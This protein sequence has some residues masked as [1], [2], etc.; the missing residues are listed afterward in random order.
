VWP[1]LDDE[2]RDGDAEALRGLRGRVLLEPVRV[3]AA[4]RDDEDLVSGKAPQ[5]VLDR[6]HGIAVADLGF[7]PGSLGL[8]GLPGLSGDVGSLAAR[9][10]L[11]VGKPLERRDVRRRRDDAHFRIR[12]CMVA[13][14]RT[15]LGG[16][17]RRR[18][19]DQQSLPAH[20]P[21]I[22]ERGRKENG[23]RAETRSMRLHL[24]A[25]LIAAIVALTAAA[26][27]GA[28][29]DGE[30]DTAHPYVGIL[31]TVIDGETAPVCSGFLVSST[32]FVTAAHCIDD[33]G[34][35]LPAYVSFARTFDDS[36][37]VIHGTAVA[38]PLFTGGT[39]HDIAAVILDKAVT[40]RGTATVPEEDVLEDTARSAALT[41]VGYGANGFT[42]GAPESDLTRRA[43]DARL[44][45]LERGKYS[46]NLRMSKGICFGDSGGP[47]LLGDSD[48]VVGISS[49]VKS[50]KC[51]GNAYAFRTDTREALSFLADL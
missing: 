43:A 9:F 42:K 21:P 37:S 14:P 7:D 22:P 44:V 19:H 24:R 48:V 26:P 30:P 38:N 31:V 34:G 49:F 15:Q 12:P 35:T 17:D 10:V 1:G 51:Q 28:V 23:E 8:R 47:V 41:L 39:E 4:V 27:S 50:A 25:F 3:V 18:R 2:L 5:G 29:L 20:V 16:L 33:L 11:V 40:G 32:L 36:S 45:K 46:L 13:Q 6:L